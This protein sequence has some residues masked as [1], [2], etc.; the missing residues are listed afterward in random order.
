MGALDAHDRRES[1]ETTVERVTTAAGVVAP[2]VA[3]GSIFL[4]TVLSGEFSW[5]EDPL[6]FLGAV[7]QPTRSLFNYGL[8]LG[9]VISLPFAYRLVQTS[10]GRVERI[11]GVAFAFAGVAMALIGVFPMGA[12]YHFPA[13][14][15][16]YLLVTVT[17]VL[18]G[19]G[20]VLVGD[21]RLGALTIGL[22]VLNVAAWVVYLTVFEPTGLSL[23]APEIVGALA[24]GGWTTGTAVRLA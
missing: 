4:A 14:A 12:T 6:S 1:A 19:T 24:F 5:T 9:G 17:T 8:L 16:F 23:A 22:G 15:S 21:S 3:L 7:G 20:N 10:R 2:T 11:G 13:A 18:Y